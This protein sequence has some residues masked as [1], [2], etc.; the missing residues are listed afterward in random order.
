MTAF[1]GGHVNAVF[2]ASDDL[3]RF[4]DKL[5]VLGFGT[6]TR[7]PE[8]PDALVTGNV[9]QMFKEQRADSVALERIGY[10]DGDLCPPALIAFLQRGIAA[11]AD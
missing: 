10:Y 4:R 7:F 6:D 2:G 3:T 5:R 1:L 8:F 11:H 9:C